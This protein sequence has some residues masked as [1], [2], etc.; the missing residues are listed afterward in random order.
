[1]LTP[2]ILVV[3]VAAAAVAVNI[4]LF[5]RS[6]E[7]AE[8][9]AAKKKQS[10]LFSIAAAAALCLLFV[11]LIVLQH[12]C[13]AGFDDALP[14]SVAILFSVCVQG[15]GILKVWCR[16]ERW[17]RFGRSLAILSAVLFVLEIAV[18]NGKSFTLDDR[19][20]YISADFMETEN[21]T[22]VGYSDGML[23][24]KE[25]ADIRIADLP[26]WINAVSL[27]LEQDEKQRPFKV[28]VSIMDEN[29][30]TAYH[31]VGAKLTST[32]GED[33]SFA[34]RPHGDLHSLQLSFS[35][36]MGP[37]KLHSVTASAAIP[38]AFSALRYFL[39]FFLIGLVLLIKELRLAYIVF[40]YDNLNHRRAVLLVIALCLFSSLLFL[41]PK[42]SLIQYPENFIAEYADP[43]AQTLDA[44]ESGHPWLNVPYDPNL[45]TLGDQ[46]YD[47]NV[48]EASGFKYAWDRA[49]YDGKFYCYFGITPVLTFYYPVYWI[50]GDLPTPY[51]AC[52][53]YSSLAI[54]F[55]CMAIL[56][57]VRHFAAKPNLLLL[58]LSLPTATALC[59]VYYCVQF[60]NIYN[61]V[62]ASGLCFLFLALWMG[63]QACLSEKK[64][65]RFTFFAICGVACV[66]C[67]ASRPSMA[68]GALI[69]A[70]V[71]LGVLL[72]K[73]QPLKYRLTQAASFLIPVVIGAAGLM[74]YNYI[75][76]D[77]FTEFGARYQLTISNINANHLRLSALPASFYHYF[78]Q[79][80]AIKHVF[81]FFTFSYHVLDNY[82]MY[83][84]QEKCMGILMFPMILL[85]MLLLPKALRARRMLGGTATRLQTKGFL[86]CCFALAIVIA[87]MDLCLAGVSIR[88]MLDFVSLLI[89]GSIITML[90]TARPGRYTYTLSIGATLSTFAMMWLLML[91]ISMEGLAFTTLPSQFPM[92]H[93][94]LEELI[95]FWS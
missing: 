3:L 27:E 63:F 39:L 78:L 16:N 33:L 83:N 80:P 68:L 19:T 31:M 48:R 74:Y 14:S 1:M 29:F 11:L 76:F 85:G 66:L 9:K 2:F 92:L 41:I 87:W 17:C 77:S 26:G 65:V 10:L 55:L 88:Y 36:M 7:E 79:F 72:N 6:A 15:A 95:V 71:F 62:V 64:A 20:M 50:A 21:E 89:F 73:E 91:N 67:V 84:Y 81:P 34:I 24:I 22:G 69:L 57:M 43:Y 28:C 12:T 23:V 93:E 32:Y 46:V 4:I 47:R 56:A 70:P 59:G 58:L 42:Q 61:V 51:H 44:W 75:R 37:V 18:F 13:L 35:E 86:G 82:Q 38:F 45:E 53:F 40:D 25:N 8:V 60:P 90:C 94:I 54:V 49:Y 30:S 5:N 52:L